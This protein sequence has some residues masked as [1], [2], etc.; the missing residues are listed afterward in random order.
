MRALMCVAVVVLA[1]S[2]AVA[3]DATKLAGKWTIESLTRDGKN[4]DAAY[5]GGVRVHDGGKYSVTPPAGSAVPPVEGTFTADAAKTPGTID[6]KPGSGR[7]K[8]QTLQGI[9]KLEGDTLTVAF[10]EPGK[11]RPAGFE[12]KAG[13]GVVVVVHKKAK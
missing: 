4:E 9:F 1:G 11:D 2:L 7:Y 12:S 10:A 5:K 13:S 3:D 6:M 8:G